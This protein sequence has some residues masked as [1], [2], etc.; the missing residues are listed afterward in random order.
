MTTRQ[1]EHWMKRALELAEKGRG[2]TSPNPIVGACLVKTNR[3]IAEGFHR[4]F[5]AP[6]AEIEAIRRAGRKARGATL[7]VTLEP[8]STYGK[9]PPCTEAIQVA[10]ITRVV[11]G[12]IDP[13]PRHQGRGVSILKRRDV[14]VKVGVLKGEVEK[15]NEAFSKWVRTKVPFVILKMAQSLDGKIALRT[16]ASRWISGPKAR[17][18]VHHL[19]AAQDAI[20]VGKNTV[21][22]DNPRLSVRNGRVTRAPWRIVLDRKGAVSPA[23]RMFRVSGPAILVCSERFFHRVS[24]KFRN[25]KAT[26]ISVKTIK[27][28]LDLVQLLRYLGALGITSLLVEGG[29][30]VAWSF[31][32]LGLVDKVEWIFA[33]KIIG[34]RAA[35]TSVEGSG[36]NSFAQAHLI[37]PDRIVRLGNDI[38]FEGYTH[39]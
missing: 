26:I 12:A 38:L 9:T 23:A 8:C 17:M 19:R 27:G 21:L 13:N 37:R 3:L 4:S 24:K 39:S 5:G 28:K 18:W 36:I 6:H 16:G 15:Q 30:E 10:K 25:T 14:R 11:I 20:L 7:Y 34:G 33:P 2:L 32:K 29:G 1:D 22:N 35:K 31:F